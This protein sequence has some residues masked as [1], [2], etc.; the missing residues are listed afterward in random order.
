MA[1]GEQ[2]RSDELWWPSPAPSDA[3]PPATATT[4]A[5]AYRKQPFRWHGSFPQFWFS[6]HGTEQFARSFY[7]GYEWKQSPQSIRDSGR[8]CRR[9]RRPTQVRMANI[10]LTFCLQ[11]CDEFVLMFCFFVT[12]HSTVTVA[13]WNNNHHQA[14]DT[15]TF[16]RLRDTCNKM[17]VRDGHLRGSSQFALSPTLP[18]VSTHKCWFQIYIIFLCV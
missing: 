13:P 14:S 7:T 5:T 12:H 1:P 16:D 15:S 6:T 8:Q 4:P 2:L 3:P 10:C 17:F 11:K 18:R 9:S